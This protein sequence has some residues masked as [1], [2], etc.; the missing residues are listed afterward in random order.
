MQPKAYV[1][2]AMLFA[3]VAPMQGIQLPAPPPPPPAFRLR[4]RFR[5]HR[6]GGAPHHQ[7]RPACQNDA[8]PAAPPQAP[9]PPAYG[10]TAPLKRFTQKSAEPPPPGPPLPW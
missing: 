9:S 6:S 2:A 10:K 8:P 7:P 3:S 1:L 5:R 4:R